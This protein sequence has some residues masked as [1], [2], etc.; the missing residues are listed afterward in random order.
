MQ[1]LQNKHSSIK[2]PSAPGHAHACARTRA[3]KGDQSLRSTALDDASLKPNG[4]T[5][6]SMGQ[7][8]K[9]KDSELYLLPLQAGAY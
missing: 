3:Y 7:H 6:D 4:P 9:T 1:T 8:G 2:K 5:R